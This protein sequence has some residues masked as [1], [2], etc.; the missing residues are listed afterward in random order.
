MLAG[1][2]NTILFNLL[3]QS[4]TVDCV[5]LDLSA[6]PAACVIFNTVY[7]DTSGTLTNCKLPAS[8]AETSLTYSSVPYPARFAMYNCDSA[9]TNYNTYGVTIAGAVVD[10]TTIYRDAGVKLRDQNN[11][12]TGYSLKCT[13]TSNAQEIIAPLVTDALLRNY[14]GTAAEVSAFAPGASK[15]VTVEITH[16]AAALLTDAQAWLEVSYRGTDGNSLGV[17]ARTRRAS[18]AATAVAHP[19][20]TENWIGTAQTYKQK[21]QATITSQCPGVIEV[22]V[23]L[24]TGNGVIVYVDPMITVS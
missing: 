14:P 4:A 3:Y 6:L 11:A 17:V 21:L 20:S 2:A 10:N 9:D 5:G 8:W 15:T 23:F 19:T 24:A 1:S 13:T 18:P 22:R 7:E 12:L 16:S